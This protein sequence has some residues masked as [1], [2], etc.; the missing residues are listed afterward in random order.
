LTTK[1]KIKIFSGVIPGA[2]DSNGSSE[3]FLTADVE[4]ASSDFKKGF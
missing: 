4:A 2:R 1:T 3:Q